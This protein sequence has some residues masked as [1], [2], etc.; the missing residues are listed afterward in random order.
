MTGGVPV[1]LRDQ[2]TDVK[3][4]VGESAFHFSSIKAS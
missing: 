2:W 3:A 1:R 4:H